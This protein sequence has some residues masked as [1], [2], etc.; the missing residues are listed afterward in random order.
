[1]SNE[2]AICYSSIHSFIYVTIQQSSIM[3][4]QLLVDWW[5][6]V[7]FLKDLTVHYLVVAANLKV[8]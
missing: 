3:H 4:L 7:L 1:M 5:D 8:P 6:N 2:Q